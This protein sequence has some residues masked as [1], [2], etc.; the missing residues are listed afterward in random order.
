VRE[1][2]IT[3]EFI[4]HDSFHKGS[5]LISVLRPEWY[6]FQRRNNMNRISNPHF[7]KSVDGSLKP[8]V[9]FLHKNGFKTTPSCAGHHRGEKNY[10]QIYDALKED[11]KEIRSTGLLLRDVET[12]KKTV[13]KDP[14]YKLP[15]NKRQFQTGAMK[16]QQTGVIG[17]RLGK[18]YKLREEILKINLPN[19][20]IKEVDHITLLLTVNNKG[21][22]QAIWNKI[23]AVI[24]RIINNS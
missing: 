9:R 14:T 4:P 20:I 10:E 17:I 11:E 5:W 24:K 16:Y 19:V 15:W 8:L 18:R 21:Y 1:S 13:F 3:P 12:N 2:G 22:N 6:Y 23:T 7:M